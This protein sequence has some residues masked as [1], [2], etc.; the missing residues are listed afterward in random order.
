MKRY[1]NRIAALAFTLALVS[2][3][4]AA[5]LA[6]NPVY[7]SPNHGPGFSLLGDFGRG[8]NDESGKTNFYGGRA[9]LGLPMASFSAGAGVWDANV[10]GLDKEITFMGSAAVNV[11]K[12]PLVPVAV[13]IQ[14]G[15]GYLK[16]G[17]G[18][19]EA[20]FWNFPIGIGFAIDAPSPVV[21]VE[22]WAAPR[23]HIRR[24][25]VGGNSATQFGFGASAGLN[26][27]LPA[28]LG[29]HA[30]LDWA[31]FSEKTSGPLNLAEVKPLIVGVGAHYRFSI[32]SLG[33]PGM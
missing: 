1:W 26:L 6:G 32:P 16:T 18:V 20:K 30:V 15:A 7:F 28:G 4:A 14:A 19:T 3:S 12:G 8:V 17:S 22:P 9:I 25:S 13:S 33:I 21:D 27:T 11:V 10:T 2:N 31:R 23:I 24:V 5:Q 29:F